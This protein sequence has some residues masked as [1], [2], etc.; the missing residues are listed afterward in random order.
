MILCACVPNLYEQ[1]ILYTR[2]NYEIIFSK[3]YPLQLVTNQLEV[4]NIK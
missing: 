2:A 4:L 1:A 3:N